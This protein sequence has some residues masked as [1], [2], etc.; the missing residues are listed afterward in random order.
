MRDENGVETHDFW[1]AESVDTKGAVEPLPFRAK[2][3]AAQLDHSRQCTLVPPLA[4][5]VTPA[6]RL[7]VRLRVR[8]MGMDVLN[9]LVESGHLAAEI[10]A[11]MQTLTVMSW[12][13][14]YNAKTDAYDLT[15]SA[16]LDCNE[17]QCLVDPTSKACAD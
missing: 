3:S 14:V 12:T 15:S 9:D 11:R 13:F 10:P 16:D 4:A 5:A 8:P 2:L 7:E 1:E 17:W 6:E